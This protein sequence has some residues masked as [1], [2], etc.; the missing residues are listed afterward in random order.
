MWPPA[1]IVIGA[2]DSSLLSLPEINDYLVVV[3]CHRDFGA[4]FIFRFSPP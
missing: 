2:L 4:V 1:M 3:R